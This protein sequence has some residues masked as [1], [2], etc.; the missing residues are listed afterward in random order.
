MVRPARPKRILVFCH[1][2]SFPGGTYGVLFEAWRQP[3]VMG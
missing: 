2:N 1:A 3:L